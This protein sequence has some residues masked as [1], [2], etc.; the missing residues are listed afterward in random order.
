[1]FSSNIWLGDPYRRFSTTISSSPVH[2][3]I[4]THIAPYT[5]PNAYQLRHHRRPNKRLHTLF[6]S[7]ESEFGDPDYD[8]ETSSALNDRLDSPHHDPNFEQFH[9][10]HLR[11]PKR[12]AHDLRNDEILLLPPSLTHLKISLH[13]HPRTIRVAIAGDM[14][15]RDV[16]KQILPQEY[17]HDARVYVKRRD[18]WIEAGSPTKVS[19][20]AQSGQSVLNERSEVEVRLVVGGRE[21]GEG[22]GRHG[23]G[24]EMGRIERMRMF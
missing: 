1:M 18:E 7:E 17:L 6:G 22:M 8:R 19:D 12:T 4:P 9:S 23:W 16:I 5:D 11:V 13:A 10:M 3:Y 21:K 2:N 24:R 15:L 14:R 20:I